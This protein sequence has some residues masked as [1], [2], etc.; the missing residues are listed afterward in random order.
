MSGTFLK[1]VK[2]RF[3]GLRTLRVLNPHW[4]R[5][6]VGGQWDEIGRLQFDFL[7]DQGLQPESYLLDVGCGSLRGG[8][9][10]IAYLKPG[11]YFGI[12]VDKALLKAGMAELRKHNLLSKN[13]TLVEM[14]DFNFR[15]LNQ[16]FD[17]ALAQ[18]VFTHLPL[19]SIMRCIMNVEKVLVQRGR[20]YATFF[21]NPDGKF[22]LEP[23][24]HPCTD[25]LTLSTFFARDPYHYASETFTWIC[26]GT[27]LKVEY[28]GD[29]NHP[30]DQKM[31]VFTKMS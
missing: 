13:P 11:R 8:V 29:W 12:D 30:R 20:F 6:A 25:G 22:N 26:E 3:T 4:Y 17:F 24:V 16:V 5:N 14:G 23:I 27:T 28:V 9:H 19:N 10:F 15:S 1:R 21:E 7:V 31:M 2:N 18:S